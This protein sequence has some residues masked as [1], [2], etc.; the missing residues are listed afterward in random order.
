MVGDGRDAGPQASCLP[1]RTSSLQAWRS[2]QDNAAPGTAGKSLMGVNDEL[3]AFC[4]VGELDGIRKGDQR[5]AG[6]DGHGAALQRGEEQA[7]GE[8]QAQQYPELRGG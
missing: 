1:A 8:L 4:G 2:K 6:P 3:G 7:D 5:H